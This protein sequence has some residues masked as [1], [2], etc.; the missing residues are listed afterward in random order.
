MS[1]LSINEGSERISRIVNDLKRYALPTIANEYQPISLNEVV[2]VSLRLT[3]NQTKIFNVTTDLLAPSPIV[4]GDAQQLHQVLINLIQNACHA[5]RQDAECYE[6]KEHINIKTCVEDKHICLVVSDKGAGM[7]RATL[8][9]ITEPFF[10]TRRSS[11]GTGLGLS[12]CSRIIK[13]H[14]ADMQITSRLGKGT[15]IKIRFPLEY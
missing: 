12:V 9:R 15:V 4:I 10:T 14:K 7:D 5:I 11:G 1:S 3:A 8:Q 13:E 6:C 2:E